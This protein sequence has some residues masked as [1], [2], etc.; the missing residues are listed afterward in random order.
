MAKGLRVFFHGSTWS[1]HEQ[2]RRLLEG[3]SIISLSFQKSSLEFIEANPDLKEM[4]LEV[5]GSF[6]LSKDGGSVDIDLQPEEARKIASLLLE[7][8]NRQPSDVLA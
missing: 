8:A 3:A 2:S 5:M 6:N 7:I 4:D 1:E